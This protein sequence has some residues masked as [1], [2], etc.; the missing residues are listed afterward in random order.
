MRKN[1]TLEQ[2]L[3]RRKAEAELPERISAARARVAV[4]CDAV[5]QSTIETQLRNRHAVLVNAG[6]ERSGMLP[7]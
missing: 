4:L 3:A 5:R 6:G 1:E 7:Q 2:E